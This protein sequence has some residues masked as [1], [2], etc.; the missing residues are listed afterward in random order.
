MTLTTLSG[1]HERTGSLCVARRQALPAAS[2]RFRIAQ[3]ASDLICATPPSTSSGR[4]AFSS[5]FVPNVA[6]KRR[7]RGMNGGLQLAKQAQAIG[8]TTVSCS[9]KT[10]PCA[11]SSE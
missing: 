9:P 1:N 8:F 11:R 2:F 10:R 6:A 7:S 4:A 5:P 3:P